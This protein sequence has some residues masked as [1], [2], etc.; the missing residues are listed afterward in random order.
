M[1]KLMTTFAIMT[2]LV[3][4]SCNEAGYT[5]QKLNGDEASLPDELKGLKIYEVATGNGVVVKVAVLNGNVN[6]VTNND[7]AHHTTIIVNK[8]NNKVIPVNQ[9]LVETDSLIV[10]K[11]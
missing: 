11:K 6:S 2:L 10:C 9:I 4:V 3:F 1:K 7:K 8:Q 5:T